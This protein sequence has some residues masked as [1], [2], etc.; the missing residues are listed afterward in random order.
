MHNKAYN[1]KNGT[2]QTVAAASG[3]ISLGGMAP[4]SY[5]IQYWNTHSGG[6]TYG[7][8]VTASN[9]WITVPA[10]NITNDIAIKIFMVRLFLPVTQR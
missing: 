10:N 3:N 2:S 6:A 4:G 8:V 5:R 7:G 1:W 9:G